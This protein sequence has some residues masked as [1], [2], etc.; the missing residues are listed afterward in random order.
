MLLAGPNITENQGTVLT[1]QDHRLDASKEQNI[2]GAK[3]FTTHDV[4]SP[5][6]E[7]LSS[8]ETGPNKRPRP[9]SDNVA[10]QR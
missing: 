3:A 5:A 4:H 8:Y 1:R 6:E 9:D 2:H 7:Y 10:Y